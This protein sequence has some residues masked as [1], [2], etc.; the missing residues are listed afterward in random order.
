M[1]E[2]GAV[3]YFQTDYT[4]TRINVE[5]HVQS[6]QKKGMKQ[7]VKEYAT[8]NKKEGLSEECR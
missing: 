5:K 8:L 2:Q 6:R 3:I 4:M 1:R 7:M